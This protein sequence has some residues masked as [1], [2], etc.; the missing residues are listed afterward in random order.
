MMGFARIFLPRIPGLTFWK[1]CGTG[2]G[3]GF[4]PRAY[5]DAFAILCCWH[6]EDVARARLASAKPF[7]WYRKRAAE[8]YTLF[9]SPVSARGQW[10][11]VPPFMPQGALPEGPIA[12]LTRAT[13][14]LDR[15][16]RFW[17]RVPNISKVIGD[18]PN[19][20]FKIGIGEVPLLHQVT[21][22]VWPDTSTMAQ[23]ARHDG[24]H[25]Q[26]IKAVR[27]GDW[28][29]EELYARFRILGAEGTWSGTHPL[30]F[31]TSPTDAAVAPKSSPPPIP[32]RSEPAYEMRLEET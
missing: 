6:S 5:P 32:A 26:A 29:K 9:L 4:T 22:S 19:V 20:M 3:E 14:K 27:S 7:P 24:P 13:V 1:L 10:A 23:F 30:T 28:F 25:A 15:A 8:T 17:R 31:D 21:F 2:T 18:D 11:G 12:A 16:V